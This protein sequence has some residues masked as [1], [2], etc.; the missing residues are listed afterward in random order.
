MDKKDILELNKKE[1]RNDEGFLDLQRRTA[2]IGRSCALILAALLQ[3]FAAT[4]PATAH[5]NGF[6]II[7][8]G[9]LGSEALAQYRIT[10]RKSTLIGGILCCAMGIY[11]LV[12][13][14]LMLSRLSSYG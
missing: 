5:G 9:I 4:K 6:N 12:E 3:L 8:M 13:Y 10:K 7:I 1:R 2:V 14:L 11:F